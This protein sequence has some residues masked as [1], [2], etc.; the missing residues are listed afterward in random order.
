M[1]CRIADLRGKEVINVCD[2]KRLGY[3]CDV[4]VDVVTGR[5]CSIIVPGDG[6][7]FGLFGKCED[8]II[9]WELIKRIGDDIILVEYSKRGG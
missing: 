4:E 7:F 1:R 5:L 8:I 6:K 9:S 3:P 2:G